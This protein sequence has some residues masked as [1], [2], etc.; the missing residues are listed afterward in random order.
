MRQTTLQSVFVKEQNDIKCKYMG[1]VFSAFV[2]KVW[3]NSKKLGLISFYSF[4]SS[5]SIHFHQLQSKKNL[6][7]QGVGDYF[8]NVDN[9]GQIN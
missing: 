7:E 8:N 3:K 9:G 4:S 1:N 2:A 6:I 5:V